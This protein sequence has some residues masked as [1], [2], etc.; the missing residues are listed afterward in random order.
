MEQKSRSVRDLL[1]VI[2]VVA[3]ACLVHGVMQG[4]HDTTEL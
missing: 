1:R 4:V 3:A 2:V